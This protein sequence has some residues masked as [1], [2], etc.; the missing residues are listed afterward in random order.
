MSI[1]IVTLVLY[2]QI[3]DLL[4]PAGDW[5]KAHPPA[6]LIP[7]AVLI[8]MSFPPVSTNKSMM[9][10]Y[11]HANH[12][13]LFGHEFVAIICG[14]VYGIGIGFAIVTAGTLLGELANFL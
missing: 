5:M 13:Q 7:I 2:N 14:L 3:V 12:P 9:R 10:N 4:R 1:T 6:W 8:I 11:S